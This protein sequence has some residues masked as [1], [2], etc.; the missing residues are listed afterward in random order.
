[1]TFV[2]CKNPVERQNMVSPIRCY[3]KQLG[4]SCATLLC[5]GSCTVPF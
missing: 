1:M 5:A 2:A 3:V 4:I